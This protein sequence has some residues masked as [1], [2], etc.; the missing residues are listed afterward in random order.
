ME[1]RTWGG[2]GNGKMRNEEGMM[3]DTRAVKGEPGPGQN[4]AMLR[5]ERDGASWQSM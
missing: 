2:L 5:I 3:K 1:V 4:K